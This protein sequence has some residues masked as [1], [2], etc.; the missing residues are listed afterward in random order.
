[1]RKKIIE[2]LKTKYRNMG[3]SEKAFD[4]VAAFIEPSVKEE[5]DIE[6]AIGGGVEALLKVFQGEGDS[7]RT[8][9][10]A[11]EKKLQELEAQIR[12]LGNGGG[13]GTAPKPESDPKPAGDAEETPAWAKALL[14]ANKALSER[15]NKLDAERTATT[16]K[17]KLAEV[18]GKLPDTF[19]K[20]Y[21][22]IALDSLKEEEFQ[23]MLQDVTTEVDGI[24]S[25]SKA[26]GAVFG[27]PVG[28]SGK[29]GSAGSG[30][31]KEASDAE[32]QAVVDR[33]SI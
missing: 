2:A 14:D 13:N 18:I 11:T 26:R 24:L 29:G 5:A 32:A 21:E 30:S 22:R 15:L 12:T 8:A 31:D 25:G 28:N 9:K 7:I 27:R 3:F 23:T 20:P 10:A 4:G 33:L 16:R 6:T 19:R 17:Q 1:M